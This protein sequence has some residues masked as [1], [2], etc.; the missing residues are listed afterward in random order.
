MTKFACGYCGAEQ[1]VER[2][3]GTVALKPIADAIARVQV[4]TDKTAAELALK[5]LPQ[6]L[7]A[8]IWQRNERNAYW[9][10]QISARET[11]SRFLEVGAFLISFCLLIPVS[12]MV[13]AALTPKSVY[14][15][16]IGLVLGLTASL[17]LLF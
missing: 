11:T 14:G 2:R 6:E 9:E 8:L 7:K 15:A 3:G 17:V 13:F 1:I 10:R 12:A 16:I 5:R 4:G